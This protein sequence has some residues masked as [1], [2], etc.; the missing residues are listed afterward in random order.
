M[1]RHPRLELPNIP[2]HIT[3]RGVNRADTFLGQGDWRAYLGT[4]LE[5]IA[6]HAVRIHAYVLMS[7]HVHLLASADQTGAISRALRDLG[8]AYVPSFNRRHSRTGTL[9]EGRFKS[10]LVDSDRYLLTAYRY[11]ELNPVRAAMVVRPDDYPWSSVHANLG[12]R[13]D[14][15]VTPHPVFAALGSTADVRGAAYR[16]WLEACINEEDTAQLRRHVQQE[17]AWGSGRFQAMVEETLQRPAGCRP[18]GRP[19]KVS[20]LVVED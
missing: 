16:E 7:N 18:R 11:I 1:P 2:L 12:A 17:R 4:L 3:H 10:C 9:W 19:R 14:P 20:E 13:T 8:R 6:R 15:L 5:S